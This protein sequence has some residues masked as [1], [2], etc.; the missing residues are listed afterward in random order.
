MI[1]INSTNDEI[2]LD[3]KFASIEEDG[4]TY[5]I[6]LQSVYQIDIGKYEWERLMQLW[7]QRY[8]DAK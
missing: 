1:I 4:A 5:H 2:L 7:E 8:K 3:G 6:Y